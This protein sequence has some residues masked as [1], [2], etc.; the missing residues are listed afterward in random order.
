MAVT[1]FDPNVWAQWTAN[2]WIN[3]AIGQYVQG[4][5]TIRSWVEYGKNGPNADA[6]YKAAANCTQRAIAAASIATAK[7]AMEAKGAG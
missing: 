1:E 3:E 7:L 6:I 4:R 5:E 2:D